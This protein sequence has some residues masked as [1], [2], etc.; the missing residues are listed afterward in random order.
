MPADQKNSKEKVS[1]IQIEYFL[2]KNLELRY[3]SITNEAELRTKGE[4]KWDMV[5]EN[6]LYRML[7]HNKVKAS[8]QQLRIL[9]GSDYVKEYNPLEE[10]F[11]DVK[12]LWNESEHG[13]YINHLASF[14]KAKDSIRFSH[15]FKKWMV[16]SV[17]CALQPSYYNKTALI[18]VGEKQNSGKSSWIRFLCPP[19]LKDYMAENISTDKDSLIAICENFLVNLDELATLSKLE[20]N[21]LKSIFSK[22]R[23]K[24]RIPYGR[25]AISMPRTASFIGSTN[26]IEFLTDATG[27]VRFMN[28]EIV[29]IDWKYSEIINMD[30][31]WSQAYQLSKS[32]YNPELTLEEVEENEMVNIAF[33]VTTSEMELVMKYLIPGKSDDYEVFFQTTDILKFLLEKIN[34]SIRINIINLGKA[35]KMLGFKQEQ[36]KGHRDKAF[37]VKGYYL[38]IKE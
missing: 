5:N 34:G 17:L 23:V 37:P 26:N 16:R 29:D 33:R 13:D 36:K 11:K 22:D 2:N 21:A 25:K 10:Y 7:H 27:S 20:I 4:K 31:A 28:F 14:V 38:K 24:V 30:I 1:L 3:N 19:R 12:D 8:I 32:N 18:I 35:L 6:S 15:Q 9:L